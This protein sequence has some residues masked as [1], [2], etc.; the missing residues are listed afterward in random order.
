MH[1]AATVCRYSLLC[2]PLP[3]KG[4]ELFNSCRLVTS[5]SKGL[6]KSS[7]KHPLTFYR[8]N[9]FQ[10]GNGIESVYWCQVNTV[11]VFVTETFREYDLYKSPA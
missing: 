4:R 5:D 3:H 10:S 11:R 7:V 1:G 2:M 8:G 9:L 6:R